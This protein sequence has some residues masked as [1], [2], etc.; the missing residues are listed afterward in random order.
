VEVLENLEDLL[1]VQEVLKVE[2]LKDLEAEVL[3]DLEVEVLKELK[4]LED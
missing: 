1:N 4:D 2:V 3:K